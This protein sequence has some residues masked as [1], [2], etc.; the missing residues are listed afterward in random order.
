MHITHHIAMRLANERISALRADASRGRR[1]V[2]LRPVRRPRLVRRRQL[3]VPAQ[4]AE[5]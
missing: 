3:A 4:R 1:P 2:R 5:R